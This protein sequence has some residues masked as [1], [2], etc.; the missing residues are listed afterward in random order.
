MHGEL[1][2]EEPR[3]KISTRASYLYA[4]NN[5]AVKKYP[6]FKVKALFKGCKRKS[7]G[8]FSSEW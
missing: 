8:I 6:L 2:D 3:S 7:R 1:S 5:Y 4:L